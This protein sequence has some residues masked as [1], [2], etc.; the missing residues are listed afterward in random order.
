MFSKKYILVD[1]DEDEDPFLMIL[2][3]KNGYIGD[4]LEKSNNFMN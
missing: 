2:E 1:E 4:F 3:G